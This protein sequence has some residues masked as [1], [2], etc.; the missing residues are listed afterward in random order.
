MRLWKIAAT[1]VSRVAPR[2]GASAWRS[3]ARRADEQIERTGRL[4]GQECRPQAHERQ[5]GQVQ[6]RHP[7]L[8]E[9]GLI[10][11]L[12]GPSGKAHH[13]CPEARELWIDLRHDRI[14]VVRVRVD[15]V[16]PKNIDR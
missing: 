7:V 6:L 1:F 14:C 12:K 8:D 2:V 15:M 5:C 16:D 10:D 11:A 4:A 13:A 9:I 3:A